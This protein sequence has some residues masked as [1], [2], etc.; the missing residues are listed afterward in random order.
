VSLTSHWSIVLNLCYAGLI[1]THSAI[2]TVLSIDDAG[3]HV[4][5]RTA[6]LMALVSALMSLGFGGAYTIRFSSLKTPTRGLAWVLVRDVISNPGADLNSNLQD[7]KTMTSPL[8]WNI[9]TFLSLPA[10]WLAWSGLFFCVTIASF[11]WTSGDRQTPFLNWD[12]NGGVV[13][14]VLHPI[15]TVVLVPRV[16]I[17]ALFLIGFVY[18]IQAARFLTRWAGLN[19]SVEKDRK[20]D[21]RV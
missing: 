16:L 14:D 6:A 5:T 21:E 12:G 11:V 4:I 7:T 15:S 13:V 3:H 1:G 18:G 9:W 20:V 19:A 2:L 8:I 10:A 17:S